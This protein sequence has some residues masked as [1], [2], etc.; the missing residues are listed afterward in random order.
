MRWPRTIAG[1]DLAMH[2]RF[3]GE[4]NNR[5]RPRVF[6]PASFACG[7]LGISSWRPRRHRHW[8]KAGA[9]RDRSW[10]ATYTALAG[11]TPLILKARY[12]QEFN[13]ENRWET[14]G[15]REPSTGR[16]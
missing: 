2:P 13:V 3:G 9:R 6:W 14:S 10:A 4:I 5:G 12:Y 11:K 16:Q 8:G 1:I 15:S 7:R